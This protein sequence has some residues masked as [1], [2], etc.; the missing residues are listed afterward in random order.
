MLT[1]NDLKTWLHKVGGQTDKA[2]LVLG[3]F[4]EAVS[5]A[6]LKER[7]ASAGLKMGKSWNPSTILRRTNGLA[8]RVPD[9]WE[10]TDSGRQH[11]LNLGV[12]AMRPATV[13]IAASLRRNALEITNLDAR[14]FADEAIRCYETELYRSAVIMSWVGAVALLYDYVVKH[15]LADFN[16]EAS[17]VD[18]RWKNAVNSDDLARMKEGDFLDR[19]AALS[20]LGKNTKE[21]LKIQLDLRNA[22]GHPNSFKIGPHTV[23]SHIETLILNVF[24]VFT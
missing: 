19:L 15:R 13:Q 24:K 17:R 20:I 3:S 5:V 7:A 2:L 1:L 8:I 10:I 16:A 11:L 22:C 6:R 23:T 9:G 21:R 18:G 4:D 12:E 14:A